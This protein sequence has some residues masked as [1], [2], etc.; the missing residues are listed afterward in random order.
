MRRYKDDSPIAIAVK[1]IENTM[2]RLGLTLEVEGGRI[3]FSM[4]GMSAVYL[5][6]NGDDA[7]SFPYSFERK[8]C[9]PER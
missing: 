7:T 2:D 9:I 8:L 6:V 4:K 1:E 3:Y 5:D